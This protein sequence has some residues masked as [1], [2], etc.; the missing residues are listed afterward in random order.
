M[1]NPLPVPTVI[2]PW[3]VKLTPVG[4]PW[5]PCTENTPLLRFIAKLPRALGPPRPFN[6]WAEAPV[7]VML[8]EFAVI[9]VYC[10]FSNTIVP[11]TENV[12]PVKIPLDRF[13]IWP[14]TLSVLPALTIRVPEF[15]NP[16]PAET[17]VSGFAWLAMTVPLLVKP[18][19]FESPILPEPLMVVWLARLFVTAH[20]KRQLLPF[21]WTVPLPVR[22]VGPLI[23]RQPFA[24]AKVPVL[25][26]VPFRLRAS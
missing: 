5:P 7:R 2:V 25:L 23:A 26:I 19:G 20:P 9:V 13:F 4:R 6:I 21:I 17:I 22:V 16:L 14:L 10:A 24:S 15:E 8:A 3:F 18:I 1:P 11:A 12:P